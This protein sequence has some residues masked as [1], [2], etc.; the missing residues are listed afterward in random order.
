MSGCNSASFITKEGRRTGRE[1]VREEKD[2]T[3]EREQLVRRGK[4]KKTWGTRGHMEA[5]GGKTGKYYI[6]HPR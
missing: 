5:E 6:V 1:D 2:N 4:A 3:R